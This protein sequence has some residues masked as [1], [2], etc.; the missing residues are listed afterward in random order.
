M[1]VMKIRV[2]LFF[3]I[4]ISVFS[5]LGQKD[6]VKGELL[7]TNMRIQLECSEAID[8][9]YNGNFLVAEKQFGWIQEKYPNHPLGDFLMALSQ[10][11]KI[12]PNESE[13][14]YDKKF[15]FYLQ[16]TID[17]AKVIHKE[18]K[19]NPEANFFL[20]A[21]YGFKAQR[22]AENDRIIAAIGPSEKAS[23]YI[24][25]NLDIANEE[26][27]AEFLYGIGLYN[28]FREWIPI[29]KP[30]L[31]PVIMTFRKG[32]AG[33][34]LKQINEV[35]NQSFYSRIEALVMLMDI[36]S[37]YGIFKEGSK[38]KSF[39]MREALDISKN[40]YKTY[41]NNRYFESRYAQLCVSTG[42]DVPTGLKIMK[43]NIGKE[44]N[45][46]GYMNIKDKR[47]F[48]YVYGSYLYRND[49]IDKSIPYLETMVEVSEE[50]DLLSLGYSMHALYDLAL[51]YENR[52]EKTEALKYYELLE[53]NY[54]RKKGHKYV[55]EHKTHFKEAKEYIKENGER[56]F[57]GIF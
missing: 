7:L 5:V 31:K 4:L 16:E 17:K 50:L 24:T 2:G 19:T 46:P 11:W 30:S 22:L 49:S 14:K 26:Y 10:R 27:G 23:D 37:D 8:S 42:I 56:K 40:L 15:F 29:Y 51:E 53:D 13:K 3:G 55:L 52:G 43:K 45:D 18:D 12:M 44:K 33:L 41:S 25:K 47:Y 34:G 35:A 54:S 9:L 32:D 20:A 38:I 57:L 28:Y 48:N 6:T 1:S 21:A 39:K 36:Y